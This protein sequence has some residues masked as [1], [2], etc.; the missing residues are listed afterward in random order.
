MV[1]AAP[2]HES[3]FAD[4]RRSPPRPHETLG[5]LMFVYRADSRNGRCA[6]GCHRP[7]ICSADD[8]CRNRR[9][10]TLSGDGRNFTRQ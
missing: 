4:L 10:P 1:R 5:F 6:S 3:R 7:S 2:R 9:K 8:V